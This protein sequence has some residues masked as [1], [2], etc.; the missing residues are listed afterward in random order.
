MR[1]HGHATMSV[2]VLG[3]GQDYAVLGPDLPDTWRLLCGL[4][5]QMHG[6]CLWTAGLPALAGQS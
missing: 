4:N 1:V 5:C 2:R 6:D 3:S